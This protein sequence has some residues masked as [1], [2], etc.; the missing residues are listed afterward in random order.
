MIKIKSERE[1]QL[2]RNAGN[3]MKEVF[4]ALKAEIKPG[5]STWDLNLIIKK[6]I[7]SNSATSAEYKYPNHI[8]GKPAFP[9]HA[10]ISVNDVIIHGV[11]KKDQILKSGDIV[12]VDLVIQ[13][14][15]YN[16]DAARTFAVGNIS[17]VAKKLIQT[18]E[19]AFFEAMEVAKE[20]YRIGDISNTIENYV[21]KH[22][23]NVIHEYQGHGIGK[24]MH[25]EPRNPK[26][27]KKRSG[28]KTSKRY[29]T[30]G[31]TNGNRG[32]KIYR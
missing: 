4:A 22:G 29:D 24:D 2:M 7:E 25:E 9:G 32:S 18:T 10:C 16:V 27:W 12:T 6:I 1:I 26:L 3:I 30:C 13:K 14:D 20:G 11:P 17:N 31:R 23:F 8:K 19:N 21:K 28:S 5:M 15:G